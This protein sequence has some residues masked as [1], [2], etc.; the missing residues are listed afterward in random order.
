[1]IFIGDYLGYVTP[2]CIWIWKQY[3]VKAIFKPNLDIF[4]WVKI[5]LKTFNEKSI[6]KMFCT[7]YFKSICISCKSDTKK[8]NSSETF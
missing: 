3:I 7:P 4:P 6:I 2:Y 1:M 8:Q 5:L